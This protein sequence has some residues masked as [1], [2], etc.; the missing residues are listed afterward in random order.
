MVSRKNRP[1]ELVDMGKLMSG[2]G[3][4]PLVL[5]RF[6]HLL[7]LRRQRRF[8]DWDGRPARRGEHRHTDPYK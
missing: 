5:W 2:A 1:T 7:L 3:V 8:Q 6:R 4:D